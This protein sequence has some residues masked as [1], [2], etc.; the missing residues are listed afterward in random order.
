MDIRQ[1]RHF[2]VL[3]ETLNYHQAAQ[4]LHMSQP[5]L[6]VSIRKLEER[7]GVRLFE[8]TRRGTELTAAGQAALED[9]RRA[10]FHVEQVGRTATAADCGEAGTLRVGFVGSATYALM[11]RLVPAFRAR[12][13]D[14]QLIL[15][16]STT[17][18]LLEDIERG[19]IDAGL[20]RFPVTRASTASILLA[21]R[22]VFVA[23]LP[24]WHPLAR[25]RR[26]PLGAL[27]NEPFVLYSAAAVP[28]LHAMTLL[29]CQRAGFVP[30]VQQEAVQV[31]T[32]VSLVGSGLGV[33]LV[34]SVTLRHATEGVVFRPLQGPGAETQ[35]G[36]ALAWRSDRETPATRR[37]RETLQTLAPD[38]VRVGIGA[39][40]C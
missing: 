18:Q 7:L 10:L 9:A 29:A 28:G 19:G 4:R 38:A 25:K 1:L 35:I 34:P 31:Q 33:A 30:Q 16:E 22:D 11:P 40:P 12:Y 8:R 2:V 26:I 39:G 23:A 5:P 21:E 17:R 20:L 13:P 14:V 6:S 24:A 36:I 37:F 3:A 27:A 32:V 15:V